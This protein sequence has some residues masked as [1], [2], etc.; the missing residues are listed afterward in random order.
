MITL[1]FSMTFDRNIVTHMPI[2]RKRLGKHIPEVRLSTTGH[3]LL[4]N[5]PI[6]THS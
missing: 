3:P 2:A 5:G 4:G 6:N 1:C